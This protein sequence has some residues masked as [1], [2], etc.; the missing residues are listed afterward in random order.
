M[1]SEELSWWEF[2]EEY[3]KSEYATV[4]LADFLIPNATGYRTPG[5]PMA[6]TT[7]LKKEWNKLMKGGK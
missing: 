3:Q 4:A 2:V 1:K 6:V 7:L 5:S